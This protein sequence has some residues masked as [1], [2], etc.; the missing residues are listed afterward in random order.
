ME[1]QMSAAPGGPLNPSLKT[2]LNSPLI[3]RIAMFVAAACGLHC[4]CFPILLAITTA[5]TFVR[6]L[7][8]PVEKGFL[9]SAFVLETA[10]L[11]GS[12]WRRHHRPECLVLSRSG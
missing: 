12:W 11:S 10:N 9:V 1:R 2:K 3:D 5:S 4:V 7:S 6:L 8:E